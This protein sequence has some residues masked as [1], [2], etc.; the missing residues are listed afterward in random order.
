MLYTNNTLV[1]I[2]K[3]P[4]DLTLV[5]NENWYRIP[6]K[7]APNIVAHQKVKYL[8]FY[9]HSNFGND[10]YQI[11][12]WGKVKRIETVMRVSLFPNEAINE[13]S[14][15]LYYKLDLQEVN[16]L[17]HPV[18]NPTKRKII[19]LETNDI[20][21]KESFV[22]N[23][24]YNDSYLENILY[25]NLIE[26]EILCERQWKVRA[27]DKNYLLDFAIFCKKGNIC[28]ECDGDSYHEGIAKVIKDE[29]RDK[30]ISDYGWYI[31]RFRTDELIT[32]KAL[33]NSIRI[34]QDKVEKLGGIIM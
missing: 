34:I 3:E 31:L 19:F 30:N 24:L 1:C 10:A 14:E 15:K 8:A 2:L 20:L 21:L 7:Q 22:I 16:L 26:K 11:Q 25:K 12:Y 28:V 13:K 9:Q 27:N 29:E 17:Q 23:S 33:A 5:L 4:S 32:Q 18:Y 6:L